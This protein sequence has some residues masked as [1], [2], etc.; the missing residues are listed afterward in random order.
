ME[1]KKVRKVWL[2]KYAL[3]GGI[4]ETTTH[5][6]CIG[7]P[8]IKVEARS[9]RIYKLGRDVHLSREGA[10]KAA[11]AMRKKKIASLQK[12]LKALEALKF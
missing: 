10:V 4:E 11:D 5:Y 6:D 12:Q 1:V 8:Y 9:Y 7:N 2:T 3:T